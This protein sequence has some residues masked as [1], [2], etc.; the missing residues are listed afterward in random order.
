MRSLCKFLPTMLFGALV[1]A[2]SP[3]AL[4]NVLV[5]SDG[6]SRAD[7]IAYG[8]GPRQRLDVYR[9]N[10][11]SGPSPVMV[12]FYGGSWKSGERGDYEFVGEAFSR[13]GFTVVVP[14]YRVYPDVRF[15]DFVR[16][17]ARA[18]RWTRD[19]IGAYGGDPQRIFVAG[20]SAGAHIAALLAYDPRYLKAV[21]L[22]HR[23]ICGL[24]GLAGPYAFDP[25]SV[26]TVRPIF[27]HLA[28]PDAARPITY[29]GNKGPPALLFHG[30]E[31]SVVKPL[32]TRMLA[33]AL[34][35]AGT[36][37]RLEMLPELGHAGI[38]L[39][40]SRPFDDWAPVHAAITDFVRKRGDC[41]R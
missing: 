32:N 4:V 38:L 11:R 20:H 9:G 14:D 6:Y 34:A 37:A 21:G 23:D 25:L 7:G 33:K 24:V 15:P 18:L 2:C 39:A 31:D 5:P 40:L 36:P 30:L 17:A 13:R 41:R 22:N 10:G 8:P 28:D 35:Q 29:A 1:A 3:L 12:F 26:R 19:N 16:D 27:V